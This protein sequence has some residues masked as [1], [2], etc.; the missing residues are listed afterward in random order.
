MSLNR[1]KIEQVS[2]QICHHK[3]VRSTVRNIW[4]TSVLVPLQERKKFFCFNLKNQHQDFDCLFFLTVSMCPRYF[5]TLSEHC[6]HKQARNKGKRPQ[7]KVGAPEIWCLGTRVLVPSQECKKF[8]VLI[9][10][11]S[12]RILIVFY[13]NGLYM[14]PIFLN[15][16]SA[17][18]AQTDS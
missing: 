2:L 10:R 6:Q 1:H 3:N 9:S 4:G 17:L 5:L 8:F 18:Q 7:K 12:I 14:S 13:F 15:F 16:I 11:T